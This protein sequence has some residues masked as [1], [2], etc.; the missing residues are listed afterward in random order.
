MGGL[1]KK[2][3]LK[4]LDPDL[5]CLGETFNTPALPSDHVAG[6]LTAEVAKRVRL[7]AGIPVAVGA[8]DAHLGAVG[9]GIKPGTLVKIIG[10]S[11]AT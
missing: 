4:S 3:F 8:L 6:F 10:T 5:A 7:P 2:A 1:P 9:A 11:T